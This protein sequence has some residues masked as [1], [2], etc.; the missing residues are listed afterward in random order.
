MRALCL[1]PL[2]AWLSACSVSIPLPSLLSEDD[3]TGSISS[4]AAVAPKTKAALPPGTAFE[5]ADWPVAHVALTRAL[6]GAEPAAVA[7]TNPK[8]GASGRFQPESTAAGNPDPN[9][10]GFTAD[11]ESRK[12]PQALKGLACRS[13]EGVWKIAETG[14]RAG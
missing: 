3:A 5:A 2:A 8:T 12:G 10:R 7:W 4:A 6:E 1:F 9:C 11:I 13:A 14:P